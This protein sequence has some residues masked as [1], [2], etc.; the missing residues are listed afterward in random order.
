MKNILSEMKS[1]LER[2]N[3]MDKEEDRITDIEDE[4]DKDTQSEWQEKRS[5][6]YNNNKKSLRDKIKCKN[7][8]VIGVLEGEQ[9]AE[10]I[11]EEIMM[12][13]LSH[14]VKEIDTQPQESQRSPKK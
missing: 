4:E 3:R 11:F 10:Y 13:N 1:I 14:L 5:Q 7:I 6:D 9:E 12:E 8:H 2:I